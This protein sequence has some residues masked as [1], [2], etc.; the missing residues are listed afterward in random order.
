MNI[1]GIE[2]YHFE[3]TFTAI[4]F[5]VLP[6]FLIVLLNVALL[7]QYRSSA[8]APIAS[9]VTQKQSNGR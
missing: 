4:V 5:P 1:L 7:I 3:K 2:F 9:A 8:D 6:C